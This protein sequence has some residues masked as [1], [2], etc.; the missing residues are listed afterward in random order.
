MAEP[1]T[2]NTADRQ[3]FLQALPWHLNGTL[4]APE[5]AWVEETLRRSPWATQALAR[6]QALLQSIA[7][8][9]PADA[10]LGLQTLLSRVR[11]APQR[12]AAPQA[13]ASWAQTLWAWLATPQ[14]GAAMAAVVLAQAL[15]IGWMVSAPPADSGMRST[16]VTEVRTLRVVFVPEATEAQLRSALR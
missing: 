5:R 14:L 15:L 6:E 12:V 3:R 4:D 16:P 9:Q 1:D 7:A 13:A 10:D 11:P 2:L 8:P